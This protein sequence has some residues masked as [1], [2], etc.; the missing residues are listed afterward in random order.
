MTSLSKVTKSMTKIIFMTLSEIKTV[1]PPHNIVR[2]YCLREKIIFKKLGHSILR[3]Q[4]VRPYKISKVR[5]PD[6]NPTFV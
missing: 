1:R 2:P 6:P 3:P 5:T 4:K